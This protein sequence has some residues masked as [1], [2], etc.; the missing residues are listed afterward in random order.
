MKIT[1]K[2]LVLDKEA[3]NNLYLKNEWYAYTNNPTELFGSIQNSIDVIAAYDGDLLVGLIRTIG[4]Q[5]SI[6]YIQDI[7]I[8]PEYQRSGIGNTLIQMIVDQYP[9]VRSIV[10]MTD[11]GDPKSN[12]FYL[13]H[14]FKPF[15]A[16]DAIGYIYTGNKK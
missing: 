16:L 13:K 9:N 10:L 7:L 8:L 6:M 1:Y 5:H 15:E 4:D 12:S 3:I 2:D 14:G 11:K